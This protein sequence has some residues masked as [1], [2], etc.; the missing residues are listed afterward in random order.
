[1]RHEVAEV[2]VRLGVAEIRW[3]A[4]LVLLTP[5]SRPCGVRDPTASTALVALAGLTSRVVARRP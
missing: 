2:D 3:G 4:R 5:T 1:M